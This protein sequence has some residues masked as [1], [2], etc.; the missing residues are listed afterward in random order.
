MPAS[1][2]KYLK[3][4]TSRLAHY[5]RLFVFRLRLMSF[6]SSLSALAGMPHL[7]ISR[8]IIPHHFRATMIEYIYFVNIIPPIISKR[9]SRVSPRNL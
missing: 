2:Q 4:R 9:L 6:P 7:L 1:E 3:R 8:E 5:S